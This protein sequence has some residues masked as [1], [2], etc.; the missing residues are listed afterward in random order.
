MLKKW[1]I[2][3]FLATAYSVLLAHNF[4]PHQ[5]NEAKHVDHDHDTDHHHDHDNSKNEDS[6]D[7]SDIFHHFEH[8]GEAGVV[9]TST[10]YIRN[11][12]KKRITETG[13]LQIF[14]FVICAIEK[15]PLL[16]QVVRKEHPALPQ[17]FDYFFLLKA[18]PLPN[19]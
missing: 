5:H 18:P 7:P 1:V 2:F 8:I 14:N 19:A 16:N 13:L 4:T 12:E 10:Q 17:S 3:F 9:F 6:E 15:P 11:I